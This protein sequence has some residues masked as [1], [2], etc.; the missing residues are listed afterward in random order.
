[1]PQKSCRETFAFIAIKLINLDI[2][3]VCAFFVFVDIYFVIFGL[4]IN[5]NE[6]LFQLVVM[7]LIVY[8]RSIINPRFLCTTSQPTTEY[9]WV[10]KKIGG[11]FE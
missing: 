5:E 9:V 8:C 4:K 7:Y 11:K 10:Y 1:V 2:S 6:V 3:F